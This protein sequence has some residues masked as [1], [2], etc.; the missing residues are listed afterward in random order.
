LY[1]D[2]IKSDKFISTYSTYQI[3]ET[4]EVY[5]STQGQGQTLVMKGADTITR[6]VNGFLN[7]ALDLGTVAD[8]F[9]GE[10]FTLTESG[11]TVASFSLLED[12][13]VN[14][15]S[16]GINYIGDELLATASNI[17]LI[18]SENPSVWSV[19]EPDSMFEYMKNI[20]FSTF[21]AFVGVKSKSGTYKLDGVIS[22]IA[23]FAVFTPVYQYD[24][25]GRYSYLSLHWENSIGT[26]LTVVE[27]TSEV[28]M[29]VSSSTVTLIL[30]DKNDMVYGGSTD[31]SATLVF[32][33]INPGNV[34][35]DVV[36]L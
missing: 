16:V 13:D 32:K 18:D 6:Q 19:E 29:P 8:S 2:L 33:E 26:S 15:A 12:T 4:T 31:I 20:T 14:L 35:S 21:D 27:Q 7:I 36:T 22:D 23:D 24:F 5:E 10:F 25:L 9:S 11:A 1:V 17:N 30:Q 34:T 28:L 3:I